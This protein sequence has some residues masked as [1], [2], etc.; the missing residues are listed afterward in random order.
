MKKTI[1]EIENQIN[2]GAGFLTVAEVKDYFRCHKQ[3]VYD[4]LHGNN[5]CLRYCTVGKGIKR[6][7]YRI[8]AD[9]VKTFR[10]QLLQGRAV[11]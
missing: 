6:P 3:Q 4:A 5:C 8:Y 1:N 9:S 2:T 7:T 10:N 11:L